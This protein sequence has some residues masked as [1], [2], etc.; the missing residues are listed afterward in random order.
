MAMRIETIVATASSA[1]ENARLYRL[2]MIIT[3]CHVT[4]SAF[5]IGAKSTDAAH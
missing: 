1:R 3:V 2:S 4:L 5:S